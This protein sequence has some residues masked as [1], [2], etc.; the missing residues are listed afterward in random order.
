MDFDAER[1]SNKIILTVELCFRRLS[2]YSY[3]EYL[4]GVDD[5]TYRNV[6]APAIAIDHWKLL[7]NARLRDV[8]IAVRADA[9]HHR[10]VN[11]GF[12]SALA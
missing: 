7:P 6:A 4:A 8:I 11:H 1:V 3:T 10:D 9:A 2:V 5:G 12:A